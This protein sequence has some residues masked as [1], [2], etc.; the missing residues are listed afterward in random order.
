MSL[1]PSPSP[2]SRRRRLLAPALLLFAAA[3]QESLA[4]PPAAEGPVAIEASSLET[5]E[6]GSLLLHATAGG[7][8]IPGSHVAWESRDPATVRVRDGR[9]QALAPGVAWVVARRGEAA[10]SVRVVVHFAGL[11]G[12]A[13]A[14]V[15]GAGGVLVR[16]GGGGFYTQSLPSPGGGGTLLVA[17]NGAPAASRDEALSRDSVVIL[18]VPGALREGTTVLPPC[19]IDA[20]AGITCVRSGVMVALRSGD[21]IVHWVAVRDGPLVVSKAQ[22]P[23]QPGRVPGAVSGWVSF[24]AAGLRRV[25]RGGR[26]ALEPLADTTVR[27]FVEFSLPYYHVLLGTADMS[28]SGD[29]FS[30]AEEIS[31]EPAR[32]VDG[33]LS[34]FAGG[35]FWPTDSTS[36]NAYA[37][38]W[39]PA[40]A[41]GSFPMA[42]LD[43]S[44][45]GARLGGARPWVRVEAS[46]GFFYPQ[47]G[48]IP[49]DVRHLLG[50]GGTYTVSEYR[51]PTPDAYGLLRG[52]IEAPL[53]RHPAPAGAAAPASLTYDFVAPVEP[54]NGSPW[55][56]ALLPGP[57][58]PVLQVTP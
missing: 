39:L 9:V 2:A 37:Y 22:L 31:M 44:A 11:G 50:D 49:D 47:L 58:R 48:M 43:G 54:L 6:G 33:G 13:G 5:S 35:T 4:P 51:P 23:A 38:G 19:R 16:M 36:F 25:V 45:V 7:R 53:R 15:G 52:R 12:G 21:E 29:P 1:A 20:V 8:R 3:C 18:F 46:E 27:V 34:F 10:D 24:E 28:L 14:R 40:P 41:P 30:G 57:G 26:P 42:A 17:T 56:G 32:P 55:S